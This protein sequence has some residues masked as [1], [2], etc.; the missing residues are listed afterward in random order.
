MLCGFEFAAVKMD[1]VME[2]MDCGD[3]RD[4]SSYQRTERRGDFG[5]CTKD[6]GKVRPR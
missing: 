1:S 5:G 6:D 3:H 4:A 2:V